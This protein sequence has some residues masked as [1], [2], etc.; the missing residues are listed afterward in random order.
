MKRLPAGV[1]LLLATAVVTLLLLA[2]GQTFWAD[3]L[4]SAAHSGGEGNAGGGLEDAA[5]LFRVVGLVKPVAIILLTGAV[6]VGML[7]AYHT[8]HRTPGKGSSARR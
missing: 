4:R 2:L 3:S 1:V 8:L 5:G 7:S 6:T